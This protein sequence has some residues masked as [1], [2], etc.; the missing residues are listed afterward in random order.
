MPETSRSTCSAIARS[1]S[2]CRS[3]VL[4][5]RPFCFLHDPLAEQARREGARKGGRARSN[6]ERAKKQ[7]PSAMTGD[8]LAGWLSVLFKQVLVGK[9]EPRVGTACATVARSLLDVLQ[10]TETEER[11]RAL[12][13][14]AGIGERRVG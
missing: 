10:A 7:I 8:E 1:G 3:A 12:E 4:P 14:A 2:R 13:A 5:G 9:T 6:A 11:L